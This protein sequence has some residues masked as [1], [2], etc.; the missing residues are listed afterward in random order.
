MT[1]A[2]SQ[3]F[4]VDFLKYLT[5][6]LKYLR[7]QDQLSKQLGLGGRGKFKA[8]NPV[9]HQVQD[10]PRLLLLLL[11]SS[12]FKGRCRGNGVLNACFLWYSSLFLK[13]GK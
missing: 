8:T 10:S 2:T 6:F 7:L 1:S 4:K 3:P 9:S 12:L 13:G 5:G 11:F